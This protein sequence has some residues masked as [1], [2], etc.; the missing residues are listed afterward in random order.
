MRGILVFSHILDILLLLFYK[1]I[2]LSVNPTQ[3]NLS[4]CHHLILVVQFKPACLHPL[5]YPICS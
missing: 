3:K 4:I 1:K 2:N 5:S